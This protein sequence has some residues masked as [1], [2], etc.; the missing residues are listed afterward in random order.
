MFVWSISDIKWLPMQMIRM[1]N[2]CSQGTAKIPSSPSVTD[3]YLKKEKG[4]KDVFPGSSTIHPYS[5]FDK[6]SLTMRHIILI[7]LLLCVRTYRVPLRNRVAEIMPPKASPIKTDIDYNENQLNNQMWDY[8]EV[9]AEYIQ[10]FHKVVFH[11][12]VWM[13]VWEDK[14]R[15]QKETKATAI[16]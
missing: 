10:G 13:T 1:L 7:F 12:D 4:R 15:R 6:A 3:S 5:E 8:W 2:P 11:G 14:E 9:L 16:M